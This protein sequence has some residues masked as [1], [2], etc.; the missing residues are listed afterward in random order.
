MLEIKNLHASVNGKEILKG[1]TLSLEAG[2]VHAI[3]GPN[4][5]GKST[6]GYVLSGR[7]GYEVTGGEILFNG[8][9]I[10]GLAPEERA[11]LGMFLAFQYPVEIPGVNNTYFLRTALN[12][13]RK[14][15][16]EAELDSM[17]FLKL[18]RQ[19]LSVLDLKDELLHRAVNSGFSGGEKSATKS[20]SWPCS[21]PSWPSWTKPIPA[22]ISTP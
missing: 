7:E 13:Q 6:L 14:A 9:D 1:F 12:A 11:A 19:K 5:A 10:A 22:S 16:G 21:N 15:R 3:M 4:G 2:K 8:Q 20:S 18:V 17:A